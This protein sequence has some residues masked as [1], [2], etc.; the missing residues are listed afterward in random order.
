MLPLKKTGCQWIWSDG[1]GWGLGLVVSGGFDPDRLWAHPK[2]T[3]FGAHCVRPKSLSRFCE[4]P[5]VVLI[6]SHS[7]KKTPHKGAF[8]L[9]GGEGWI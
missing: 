5:S 9:F 2:G 6:D 8:S 7:N 1:L 3:S 4:P